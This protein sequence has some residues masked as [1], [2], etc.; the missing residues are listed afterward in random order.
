MDQARRNPYVILGVDYGAD[1]RT[2]NLGFAKASKRVR[3]NANAPFDSTDITWALSQVEHA[4]DS[5]SQLFSVFRIPADQAAYAVPEGNG[6]LRIPAKPM[7]RQTQPVIQERLEQLRIDAAF[8]LL[9]EFVGPASDGASPLVA[10]PDLQSTPKLWSSPPRADAPRRAATSGKSR[11]WFKEAWA[12]G[13]VAAAVLVVGGIAFLSGNQGLTPDP[14]PSVS[15]S[16]VVV[17]PTATPTATPSP[18][19]SSA[20]PKPTATA[21]A[22]ATPK[23]TKSAKPKGFAVPSGYRL[24]PGTKD[25]AYRFGGSATAPE[26]GTDGQVTIYSGQTCSL[27]EAFV[28]GEDATASSVQTTARQFD[29]RNPS[30]SIKSLNKTT[31]RFHFDEEGVDGFRMTGFTCL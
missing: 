7:S 11:P 21:S 23:E 24:V 17:S 30:T 10:R 22:A 16:E 28:S 3:Q 15:P 2:A 18:T 14:I 5:A 25:V 8:E 13:T 27:W 29:S 6:V 9:L 26:G 4:G 20:A 19:K 31:I 12:L 1:P